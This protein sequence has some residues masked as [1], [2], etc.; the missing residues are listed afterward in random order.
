MIQSLLIA[1][2]GEIACRI[3][4]TLRALT[5]GRLRF[6]ASLE[7]TFLF[8]TR[9]REGAKVMEVR[10]S[11]ILPGTSAAWW[12]AG[13][14]PPGKLGP[15]QRWRGRVARL[16]V[17]SGL[18]MI[19]IASSAQPPPSDDPCKSNS[20]TER[21]NCLGL[22][23][24]LQWRAENR[25]I[26]PVRS[27]RE[28]EIRLTLKRLFDA[29]QNRDRKVMREMAPG[30]ANVHFRTTIGGR[31]KSYGW[32]RWVKKIGKKRA[33]QSELLYVSEIW[34]LKDGTADAQVGYGY[35]ADGDE[36]RCGHAV[37]QLTRTENQWV[38][39]NFGLDEKSDGCLKI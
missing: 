22:M 14:R 15:A 4:R 28:A 26:E 30:D 23:A 16:S 10:R 39:T 5:V 27:Q 21:E 33:S 8:L 29:M 32:S 31:Q 38:A 3:I 1:N 11:K 20:T 9:R 19:S 37:I 12:V 24:Y 2:R 34:V 36:F 25:E 18:F 17:L 7:P 6:T 13:G 35:H